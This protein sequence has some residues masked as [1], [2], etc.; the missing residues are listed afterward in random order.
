MRVNCL[1]SQAREEWCRNQELCN[2]RAISDV[3]RRCQWIVRGP[4]SGRSAVKKRWQFEQKQTL[5]GGQFVG[6]GCEERRS[7]AR[8]ALCLVAGKR[9]RETR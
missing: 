1:T 2:R 6:G 5:R 3:V 7:K 9:A 4:E 8:G